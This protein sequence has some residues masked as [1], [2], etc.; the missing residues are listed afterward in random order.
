MRQTQ[1]G[2]TLIEMMIVVTIISVLAAMAVPIFR[3]YVQDARLNEAK[4]YLLEIASRERIYKARNGVYCCG[5]NTFDETVLASGLGVELSDTGNFCFAIV[6]KDAT[7]CGSVT[8]TNF[9]SAS[10]AGDPTVEFEVWA[11]LR[12]TNTTTVTGPTASTCTMPAAKYPPTGW[13]AP[14]TS[15][16]AA[17]EGRAVVFRYPPPPNG[18]DTTTGADGIAFEWVEGTS[19]S[20]ALTP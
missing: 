13:V 4:P 9:I 17:R 18:R 11:I 10:E 14:S 16:S 8:A 20:H 1:R 3:G 2:F 12:T 7:K 15:T 5:G 19:T 6:C